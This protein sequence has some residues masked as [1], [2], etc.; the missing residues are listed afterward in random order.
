MAAAAGTLAALLRFFPPGQYPIYPICL[1]RAVTGWRC[2]GCGTTR[3]LAA[4]LAGQWPEALHYN[5]L[6][7]ALAPAAALLAAVHFYHAMRYNRWAK[8]GN[9]GPLR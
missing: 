2:P 9:S 6:A 7:A 4:L 3:A 1:W 5:A 8:F